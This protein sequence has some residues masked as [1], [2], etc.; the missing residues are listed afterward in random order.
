[1]TIRALLPAICMLFLLA[2]AFRFLRTELGIPLYG[3]TNLFVQRDYPRL[4]KLP[5][6]PPCPH[7]EISNRYQEPGLLNSLA[8]RQIV[9]GV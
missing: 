7:L 4:F 9:A 8:G 5:T 1:M 3:L 6:S 2:G